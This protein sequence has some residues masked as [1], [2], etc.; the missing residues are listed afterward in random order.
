[1]TMTPLI[2]GVALRELLGRPDN[3]KVM[4][5]LPVGYPAEDAKVPDVKRKPLEQIMVVK[6]SGEE[7]WIDGGFIFDFETTI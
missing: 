3:E 5:L 4:L 6:W 2:A 1:M 7:E